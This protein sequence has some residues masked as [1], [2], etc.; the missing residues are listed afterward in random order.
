MEKLLSHIAQYILYFKAL[1]WAFLALMQF[2][3][4]TASTMLPIYNFLFLLNGIVFFCIGFSFLRAPK[5]VFRGATA[6]L[7]VNMILVCLDGFNSMDIFSIFLDL[8]VL[9]ILLQK[10]GFFVKKEEGGSL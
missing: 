9:G 10:Q 1:F 3:F 4:P 5:D 7:V 2:L 8:C 6:F